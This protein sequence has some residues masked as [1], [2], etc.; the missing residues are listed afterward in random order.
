M[1]DL[2]IIRNPIFT[3]GKIESDLKRKLA[4]IEPSLDRWK[5]EKVFDMIT[6]DFL[7]YL[8][9]KRIE[10]FEEAELGFWVSLWLSNYRK[11]VKL[12]LNK[13]EAKRLEEKHSQKKTPI[14]LDSSEREDLENL[15][16]FT[17]LNKGQLC[18]LGILARDTVKRLQFQ[19]SDLKAKNR[20][21]LVLAFALE[22]TNYC[23]GLASSSG[24]LIFIR[25][26]KG[27]Y[28]GEK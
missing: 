6:E 8:N 22:L 9:W 13:E 14:N 20:I 12:I 23:R 5:D 24:V 11:R 10:N 4:E 27:Y 17:F 16:K 1:N 3:E 28:L 18:G 2:D 26:D 15:A 21:E 7:A 19:C 25:V